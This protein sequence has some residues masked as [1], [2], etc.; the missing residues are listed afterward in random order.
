MKQNTKRGR[1]VTPQEKAILAIAEV[2]D[3][4]PFNDYNIKQK[5]MDILGVEWV[6]NNS[7]FTPSSKVI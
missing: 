3:R 6:S 7:S 2:V 1:K 5:V 4:L